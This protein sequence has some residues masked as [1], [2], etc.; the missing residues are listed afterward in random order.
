MI[1]CEQLG[2]RCFAMEIEP[3]YCDVIVERWET[4]TKRK[5]K[6]VRDTEAVIET[7]GQDET[8]AD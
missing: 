8:L 5:A 4:Y 6:L 3:K 2:R 7:D 1:A